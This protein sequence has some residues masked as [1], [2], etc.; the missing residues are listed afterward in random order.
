MEAKTAIAKE[1]AYLD[2]AS[3]GNFVDAVKSHPPGP[4]RG[5]R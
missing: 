4:G 2:L 5:K 1:L 3:K